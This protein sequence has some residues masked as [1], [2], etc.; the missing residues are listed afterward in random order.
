MRAK[1][2]DELHMQRQCS[3]NN[4]VEHSRARRSPHITEISVSTDVATGTRNCQ[5]NDVHRARGTKRTDELKARAS[6]FITN[7]FCNERLPKRQEL[8][9]SAA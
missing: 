2:C 3:N 5:R 8:V 9:A 1:E 4:E 7:I 6:V